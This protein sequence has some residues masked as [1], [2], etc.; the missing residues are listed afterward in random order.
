MSEKCR[1][2]VR[3]C[4]KLVWRGWKHNFRT[5]FG[6]FLPIWSMRLFGDPVQRSPITTQDGPFRTLLLT[7]TSP[8]ESLCGPS[9]SLFTSECSTLNFFWG[10]TMG[11]LDGGKKLKSW[12]LSDPTKIPSPPPPIA[13]QVWQYPCRTV[14]PVVSQT[15][16]A[17]PPLLPIN[18]DYRNPKTR[19][20][21]RVSQKE[22]QKWTIAVQRQALEGGYHGKSLPLEP[23]AL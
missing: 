8:P 13:R 18:I 20:G 11:C 14:F 9:T 2:N 21:R 5:F 10:P 3:K 17:T 12:F 19:L 15:I 7:Q 4:P 6:Q 16:A 1:K 22:L 23:I